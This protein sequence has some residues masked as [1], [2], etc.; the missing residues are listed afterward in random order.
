MLPVVSIGGYWLTMFAET[1]QVALREST[2]PAGLFLIPHIP[3]SRH[4]LD[5][6]KSQ[7]QPRNDA[8]EN[9]FQYTELLL[10]RI[11]MQPIENRQT[12]N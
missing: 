1:S 12:I 2:C 4:Y 7:Y 6:P 5:L 9:H 11:Q 8:M 10:L 3:H